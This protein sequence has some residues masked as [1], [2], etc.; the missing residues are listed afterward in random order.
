MAEG[1]RLESVYIARYRGFESLPHRHNLN[2]SDFAVPGVFF[3]GLEGSFL[4]NALFVEVFKVNFRLDTA[5]EFGFHQASD[6]RLEFLYIAG[7]Y[8]NVIA[9]RLPNHRAV[10]I[11]RQPPPAFERE[12]EG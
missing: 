4:L 5:V 10:V 7:F 6:A 2:P 1:A 11:V 12:A 9:H 3:L 8:P